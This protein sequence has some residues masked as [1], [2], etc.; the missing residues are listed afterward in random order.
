[1]NRRDFNQLLGMGAAGI[2][3]PNLPAFSRNVPAEALLEPGMDVSKKKR[4]A[5]A[6]LNAAKAKGATYA[7]VRIG[8][9]LNQFVLTRENKVQ[10]IIN[11]ESYGVGVR[12]IANGCW[13]FASVGDARDESVVAKAAETAVNIAKANARLLTE[14]VQLA[15]QKGFGEVSWKAPI[16]R[17]AFEVPVKEKVDLLLAANAAAM[18]NGANFVNNVLFQ[19]NEQKYFASTDGTYADQDIHRIGPNFTVTAVDPANGRFSTRNSLSAPMGMGYD[20][21]QVNP[22]DKVSG[23]TTR[24]NKGYD[25]M[26]DIVAAAK[27][28]KEKVSAKSVEAG[29]YDLILDPSHMWLTIHESVGHPLELDRVLGYEANYAGTSFATLD[30]WQTKNFNYGSKEVNFFADKIQ[31]GSL[32]AVGWDDEGVKTK[33]WD[34]V[35]DGIL[36]NYQAI[37]DQVHIIGE[38][39]SQGCCYADNWSSVQFQRMANVSLAPGKTPLTVDQMIKDVKKGIYIIGDGS[40]SID[41]QRYNFQFGGQLFYE[42]KDGQIVGMLKDVAYQANTREFWNSCVAV[43]DERDYRL[44]G[45]FNDGK[46]QPPQSSAVSHG[47]ATARFNGVNVINTARKI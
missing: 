42:I 31:P 5:D 15:P 14:P 35:K 37:R 6:A 17:N 41:Q 12:V 36:V 39:E 29:K 45:A 7:D 47:S 22:A 24:Y 34:L 28:A 8:R 26:E 10:G 27:Q 32:G 40:F 9:Y 20:Y 30:K 43:C 38:K 23:I 2:M 46:G 21:L 1:M 16:K 4:L 44:G 25:M 3:M 19:I 33:K 18:Q 11:A 13:G